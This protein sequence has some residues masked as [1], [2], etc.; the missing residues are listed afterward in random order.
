MHRLCGRLLTLRLCKPTIFRQDALT[1]L[2]PVVRAVVLPVCNRM[3]P[4]RGQTTGARVHLGA[5]NEGRN[6]RISKR[7]GSSQV[8]QA[9]RRIVQLFWSRQLRRINRDPRNASD[10]RVL[11]AN[12]ASSGTG[13][14]RRYGAAKGPGSIAR[15][16]DRTPGFTD[17]VCIPRWRN[18]SWVA[19]YPP[20]HPK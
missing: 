15:T 10:Q 11:L 6:G 18:A 4:Q 2:R 5:D 3:G 13:R 17:G 9:Q 12:T 8:R 14:P 20:A 7:R 16:S 19:P 1:A